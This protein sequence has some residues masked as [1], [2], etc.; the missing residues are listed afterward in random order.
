[1]MSMADVLD[2]RAK[3]ILR[4]YVQHLLDRL[5]VI[6]AALLFGVLFLL[7]AVLLGKVIGPARFLLYL[8]LAAL[9]LTALL[10]PLWTDVWLPHKQGGATPAMRWFGLRIVTEHGDQPSLRD[11]FVRWLLLL[12]DELFL[13][14]VGALFMAFT[15]RGQRLGDVV[16]R[17]VVV[18]A[19]REVS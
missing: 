5:V 13:G 2:V 3:M 17:T 7:I 18:R 1:M 12:V 8:P 9:V 6:V 10:G 14:L 19:A 15:P 11:Y 4:R 16:A